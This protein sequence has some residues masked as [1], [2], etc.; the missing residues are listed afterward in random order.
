MSLPEKIVT[1]CLV[2]NI[3]IV[4]LSFCIEFG[5]TGK[6]VHFPFEWHLIRKDLAFAGWTAQ[7]RCGWHPTENGYPSVGIDTAVSCWMI[8]LISNE[9]TSHISLIEQ[10][11]EPQ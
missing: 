11:K 10:I 6:F 1:V 9:Q 3:S 4:N 8:Q 2:D 7:H 5:T